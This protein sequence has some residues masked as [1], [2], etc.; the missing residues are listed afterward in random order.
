MRLY[1]P[2]TILIVILL[3]S[4]STAQEYHI[5]AQ[6]FGV[7]QGVSHR[8]VQ[9]IYQDTQGIIWLGTKYG[10]NQFDGYKFKWFTSETH[11]FQ[12]NEINHILVDHQS[13]MWLLQ[14]GS[15][16]DHT[17]RTIDLFD[18]YTQEVMPLKDAFDAVPFND[19]EV[20]SFGNNASGHLAFLT[21]NRLIMYTTEFSSVAVDLGEYEIIRQLIWTDDHFYINMDVNDRQT[22][23]LILDL[24][25]KEIN[26]IVHRPSA[27]LNFYH[28][29]SENVVQYLD[30]EY[31]DFRSNSLQFC[32]IK[33]SEMTILDS[34]PYPSI[35]DLDHVQFDQDGRIVF[36]DQE[37]WVKTSNSSFYLLSKENDVIPLSDT[38]EHL[39]YATSIFT[40]QSGVVW[41]G[42]QF[43]IYRFDIRPTLFRKLLHNRRTP[44]SGN[45]FPGRSLLVHSEY[46][47][48]HEK[49]LLAN[50]ETGG[51]WKVDLKSGEESEY[52]ASFETR[53]P[54]FKNK[55]DQVIYQLGNKIHFL[56][57]STT[58][59]DKVLSFNNYPAPSGYNY[60]HQDKY[61]HIW[62]D[63]K[64]TKDPPKIND[65]YA[66]FSDWTN[67]NKECYFSHFYEDES[68]TAW[69]ASSEGIFSIDLKNGQKIKHYH[70]HGSGK[71]HL[72]YDNIN[73][74][75]RDSD[76]RF[77]LATAGAG[78]VIWSPDDGVIDRISIED[79]LPNNTV[80]ALYEDEFNHLWI[81]T[82][83][84]I[85]AIN[86]NTKQIR[87]YEENDGLSH[88]EFNRLS[89][90][91]DEDGY[92]YF[93]GL[94]G[95]TAFHPKDFIS[96]TTA[97]N[98][99]L[100][101]VEYQQ[102]D[103][104]EGRLVDQLA[105]LRKTNTITI[106][107]GNH[108]F[109]LEFS[110]LTYNRVT[111]V[112]YAYKIEG[113]DTEWTYQKENTLRFSR[114]PY[115]NHVLR[116]KGQSLDGKWSNEELAIQIHVI[117]PFYLNFWFLGLIVSV[118]I[119]CIVYYLRYRTRRLEQ[120]K[121]NLE[122]EVAN[123]TLQ[124]QKDKKIILE[125]A[126]KLLALDDL[127]SRFF[128]NIS[129]ELR[130]P[131]TLMMGPINS[132]LKSDR[133]DSENTN[134]AK[135]VHKGSK[136]LL[137]LINE[138][139]DLTKLEAGIITLNETETKLSAFMRRVLG[140]FEGYAIKEGIKLNLIYQSE[141]EQFYL[142]DQGKLEKILNNL[143]SNALKFTS[144]G[145]LVSV[146]V[147]DSENYIHFTVSD[148]GRGIH[149]L[150]LPKVFDRFYQSEQT[151]YPKEGGTGIGLALC[152]ELSSVM[153]GQIMVESEM[154]SGSS[155]F[156]QIPKKTL[157]RNEVSDS[158]KAANGAQFEHADEALVQSTKDIH[159]IQIDN[160]STTVPS[161]L[162][163]EDNESLRAYIHSIL[164]N[165]Y[166]I[167]QMENGA[168]ALDFL[169]SSKNGKDKN[170]LYPDLILSDVMMPQM[171]GFQLL[172]KLRL[173]DHFQKIPFIMLTARTGLD[174]RL[175]AL[176]LGVDDY[177]L[178]PFEESEL[179]ARIE[180][181][182][183]NSRARQHASTGDIFTSNVT[184]YAPAPTSNNSDQM[185]LISLE[186]TTKKHLD[187]YHFTVEFLA[188]EMAYSRHQLNRRIKQL[189]G[190]TALGYIQEARMSAARSYLENRTFNSVKAVCSAIGLKDNKHFSKLYKK[191]FGRLPSSYM[192]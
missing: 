179:I 10:L 14:T 152:Q 130:T 7:D 48:S 176:R 164:Q 160:H 100:V 119:L 80:Y 168:E 44:N 133:L 155:F 173:K 74:I 27:H 188:Q 32:E 192:S 138:I 190:L 157:S 161:V 187:Q 141:P 128:A 69:I 29:E 111:D 45:Y 120:Q 93:G 102:F 91:Q 84:G 22:E 63:T 15:H 90:Y 162:I 184:E 71:L 38:Y 153:D 2:M 52:V 126:E 178:K 87:S 118:V 12:G 129:H 185:W 28:S 103:H 88:S 109:Q 42:T 115:G 110:L 8:D 174:D 70:R 108:L 183:K 51:L 127:K 124:I 182:L 112:L 140:S 31:E 62:L 98:P 43:G 37:S 177:M 122:K 136:D 4:L 158:I 97:I 131:I 104:E 39:K 47:G 150:D 41:V 54:V 101:V 60:I 78:V 107:P 172:Q 94:N 166:T 11:D 86:K 171:D 132:M 1:I 40:D 154:G 143:L 17:V 137:R 66:K 68:D 46:K 191:R 82:N 50:I 92:I 89:H 134:R 76:T 20:L 181:V 81:S 25:G 95:I 19:N 56:D 73:H 3:S 135:L 16:N 96:D 165:D 144:K 180:N 24:E 105:K 189:T 21:K 169:Q 59:T 85:A 77:W 33:G 83:N 64:R 35:Y 113:V 55:R 106:T 75:H 6:F 23:L 149:P 167:I 151:D 36:T 123:R 170:G 121:S 186:E 146:E 145:G 117:R 159:T 142:L 125:Q 18:P 58:L 147:E 30:Y 49:Y 148:T 61:G 79:G 163:V 175:K 9:C 57:A 99:P 65:T 26:R 156:L 13:R 34:F 114:L 139:F 72:P 53:I 5:N 116:V 67:K